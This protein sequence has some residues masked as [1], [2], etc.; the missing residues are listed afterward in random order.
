MDFIN[1]QNGFGVSRKLLDDCFQALLEIA[2]I[3][4]AGQQGAHVERVHRR[5]FK[6]IGYIVGYDTPCQAFSDGGLAD[7]GLAYQK[8]IVLASA[9][10]GLDDPFK[11]LCATNEWVNLAGKCLRVEVNGEGV[12]RRSGFFF[13]FHGLASCG[14]AAVIGRSV[15]RRFGNAV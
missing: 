3:L 6:Y 1:K 15:L 11:F 4:C 13:A 12:Q 7:P 14:F 2:A 5:T 10:Q 9:A 8:R